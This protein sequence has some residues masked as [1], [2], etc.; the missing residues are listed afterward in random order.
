MTKT[1]IS[2]HVFP[3]QLLNGYAKRAKKVK[4]SRTIDWIQGPLYKVTEF[5]DFS[6]PL[7]L[8]LKFQDFSRFPGPVGTLIITY[9]SDIIMSRIA[10]QITSISIDQFHRCGR[11]QRLV[12]NEPC[13]ITP[14][15][16]CFMFF[17]IKLNVLIHAPY[18]H[19][20][21]FWHNSNIPQMI[22]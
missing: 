9:Y 6:R 11:P 19:I 17:N 21:V 16:N 1:L 15:Q 8:I 3:D 5:Q 10:S 12:A 7:N 2:I 4:Y 18:T 13:V 14:C 22:L 20:V